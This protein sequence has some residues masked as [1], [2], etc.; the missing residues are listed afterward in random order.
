MGHCIHLSPVILRP[1]QISA[2]VPSELTNETYTIN[3]TIS[4]SNTVPPANNTILSTNDT[5]PTENNTIPSITA[6][7]SP[8]S[9]AVDA[10]SLQD[11]ANIPTFI[12]GLPADDHTHAFLSQFSDLRETRF[13]LIALPLTVSSLT[14]KQASWSQLGTRHRR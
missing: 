10:T 2:F 13:P 11:E 14:S 3:T 9:C 1:T 8:P 6:V 5:V 7:T 12:D 4:N